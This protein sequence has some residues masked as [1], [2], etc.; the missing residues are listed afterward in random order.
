[1]RHSFSA[2]RSSPT[3]KPKDKDVCCNRLRRSVWSQR[4]AKSLRCLVKFGGIDRTVGFSEIDVGFRSYRQHVKVGVGDFQP[5]DDERDSLGLK[6]SHLSRTNF[7][8]NDGEMPGK[9][10]GEIDPVVNFES[11]DNKC[12]AGADWS[13]RQEGD[14][15]IVSVNEP[16]WKVAVDDLGKQGAHGLG[17]VECN[18]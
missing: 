17:I 7:A 4:C 12:V 1:M 16:S 5:G 8:G 11:R 2:P 6:C 13:D 9:F 10:V 15:Q 18:E 14:A 3:A